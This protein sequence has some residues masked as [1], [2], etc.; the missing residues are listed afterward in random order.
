MLDGFLP[1]YETELP[2][3]SNEPA[4]DSEMVPTSPRDLRYT[5]LGM[6]AVGVES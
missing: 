6:T 3:A 4:A 1:T 5:G 2:S